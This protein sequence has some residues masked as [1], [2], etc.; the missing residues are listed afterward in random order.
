MRRQWPKW[1][2]CE[3]WRGAKVLAFEFTPMLGQFQCAIQNNHFD[4]GDTKQKYCCTCILFS[5]NIPE[6][7]F[8][9]TYCQCLDTFKES[10]KNSDHFWYSGTKSIQKIPDILKVKTAWPWLK[11][12]KKHIGVH[13]GLFK[14]PEWDE[15][16]T[17]DSQWVCRWR[18]A[19]EGHDF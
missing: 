19:M 16:K 15:K 8:T 2:F 13:I 10:K 4:G 5:G 11:L 17:Y 14:R 3:D 6:I 7:E 18:P 1:V 9:W 12:K